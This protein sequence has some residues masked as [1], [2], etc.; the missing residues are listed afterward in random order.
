METSNGNIQSEI[1]LTVVE[2][3]VSGFSRRKRC[4]NRLR[5]A[6]MAKAELVHS[7][8][9]PRPDQVHD[10]WGARAKSLAPNVSPNVCSS[11]LA[12]ARTIASGR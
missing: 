3:W 10:N 4:M 2:K 12:N 1:I 5:I 8:R 9:T 6:S 11:S 7:A